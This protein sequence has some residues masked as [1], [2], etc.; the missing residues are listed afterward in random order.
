MPSGY[1]I[2]FIVSY[3]F[4]HILINQTLLFYTNMYISIISNISN[5][6]NFETDQL[7]PKRRP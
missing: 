5:S 7:D 1:G 2:A 4:L 6:N 3:D